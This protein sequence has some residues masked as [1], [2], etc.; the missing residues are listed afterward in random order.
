MT[1]DC[2]L[3]DTALDPPRE[4]ALLAEQEDGSGALASFT[5]IARPLAADGREVAAMFLEH[6]PV[7]TLRSLQEIGE[8]A[9]ARFP[10]HRLRIIHRCGAIAPGE[11]IVFVAATARHRKAALEAV[12]FTMDR[13]KTDAIFWKREDRADGSE[14]IEPTADDHA[15]RAAWQDRTEG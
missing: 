6:H 5:G 7:M 3:A 4:L 15:S 12:D 13:L 1:P 8:D 2:T 9:A 10:L 14:W 11:P